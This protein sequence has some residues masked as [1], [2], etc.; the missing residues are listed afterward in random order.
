[1]YNNPDL[2]PTTK[3]LYAQHDP[4]QSHAPDPTP[5]INQNDPLRD[6]VADDVLDAHIE[7]EDEDQ[8][9][10]LDA[11]T[12]LPAR[13]ALILKMHMQGHTFTSIANMLRIT[14]TTVSRTIRK[15]SVQKAKRVY[16]RQL[17]EEFDALYEPALDALRDGL[18]VNTDI[19]TRLRAADKFLRAAGKYNNEERGAAGSS[20]IEDV[21][22]N[23]LQSLQGSTRGSARVG[24]VA[25]VNVHADDEVD[26]AHAPV[27]PETTHTHTK[28]PHK[29]TACNSDDWSD[30]IDVT[31]DR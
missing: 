23:A 25:E 20:S 8:S 2:T 13:D 12:A 18:N 31:E 22:A 4:A 7:R 30:Y 10:R 24:I 27:G 14:G 9:A 5:Q 6:E 3:K 11:M 16:M 15:K 28:P 29:N 26:D 19:E 1:M 21:L 17:D